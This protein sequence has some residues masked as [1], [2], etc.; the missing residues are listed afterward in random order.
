M[1]KKLQILLLK[2]LLDLEKEEGTY[3]GPEEHPDLLIL[4]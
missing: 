3:T 4:V 2:G 1:L